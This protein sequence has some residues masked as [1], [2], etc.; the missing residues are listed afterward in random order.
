MIGMRLAS[1]WLLALC[2]VVSQ[3]TA[4][5]EDSKDARMAAADRY[6]A[7]VPMQTMLDDMVAK[8]S[9]QAAPEQRDAFIADM[10]TFLQARRLEQIAREALVV[11]FTADEI[12]AMADFYGS[13]AGQSIL[14][15]FGDYMAQIMPAIQQEIMLALE[16]IQAREKK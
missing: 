9:A 13:P 4:W 14:H 8:L 11:I 12:G 2:V 16:K 15:K 5:A 6:L 1:R 3:A 7:V 10:K